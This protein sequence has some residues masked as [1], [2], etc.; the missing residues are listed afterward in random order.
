MKN[1]E[2]QRVPEARTEGLVVQHLADEVLVYDQRRYKAHCLNRTAA[3][4]WGRCDGEATVAEVVRLLEQECGAGVGEEAVWLALEQLG[5]A[6]LLKERV[7]K[8]GGGL[9]R[10]EVMRRMGVAA[11]VGLPMVTSI[12]AP[13]A[14]EAAN[15]KTSGQSCTTSPQCCSGLCSGGKCV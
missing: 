10:R 5:K 12:L 4:V 15:C 7:R 3:L 13:E 2:E 6:R 1:K 11:A 14:A 9:S 8:A